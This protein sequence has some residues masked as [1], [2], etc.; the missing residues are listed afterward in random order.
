MAL[1]WALA[2]ALG[3][4]AVE[5]GG[6]AEGFESAG[7]RVRP[8]KTLILSYED[9]PW[10]LA[11]RARRALALPSVGGM[12]RSL[13]SLDEAA[14]PEALADA[15]VGFLPMRGWPIFGVGQGEHRQTRPARLPAWERAWS[16]ARAH[17]ADVVIIDP[18]MSAFVGASEVLE[19]VREFLDALFAEA[20]KA[21]CG[22]LLLT[23][24]SKAGR[25]SKDRDETGEV[26]GSAA[27]TDAARGVFIL[28]R[29]EQGGAKSGRELECVK[30][31]YAPRFAA[32]LREVRETLVGD[33]FPSFLG[34]EAGCGAE[35]SVARVGATGGSG[36]ESGKE[37]IRG[38]VRGVFGVSRP[39]WAG[40]RNARDR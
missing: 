35:A 24:S 8:A 40:P 28:R 14:R 21:D 37:S 13:A 25:R 18:A 10:Q 36:A 33:R 12:P 15:R 11:R 20:E 27:W 39:S 4:A 5:A 30:A 22:V 6:G 19:F 26:G 29:G 3:S 31:N 23:H 32:S 2:G 38:H 9:D 34:F 1:Q 7:V 16:A 17:E